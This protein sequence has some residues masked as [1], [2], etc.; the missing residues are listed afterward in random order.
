M[1]QRNVVQI[2]SPAVDAQLSNSVIPVI[3][4]AT[5][6]QLDSVNIYYGVGDSPATWNEIAGYGARNFI[7]DTLA[8]WNI[9][10][11]SEGIY[12]LRLQVKNIQSEDVESRMRVL[13]TRSA[14]IVLGF[15]YQD[16]VIVQEQE[17]VLVT[18]RVDKPC[19]AGIWYRLHSPQGN[20]KE[21]VSTGIGFDHA[22]LL[23]QKDFLGGSISMIFMLKRRINREMPLRYPTVALSRNRLLYFYFSWSEY[24]D[25]RVHRII[26]DTPIRIHLK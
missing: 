16:S 8:L 22:F 10:S 3:G 1:P 9:S 23:S 19:S 13:I 14:P 15:T 21:M 17:G 12:T 6:D 4:T 20:Y 25:N 2:I 24:S 26:H 5:T 7:N 11:L 18:L